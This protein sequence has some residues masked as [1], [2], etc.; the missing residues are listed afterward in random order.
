MGKKTFLFLAFLF[1]PIIIIAQS[2]FEL[3]RTKG[4]VV[5]QNDS[6]F[7]SSNR[8]FKTHFEN[9]KLF[10]LAISGYVEK[11]SADYVVRVILK[12][13]DGHEYLVM[14]LYE[15]L[16]DS[17]LFFFNDYGEETLLLDNVVPDSIKVFLKDADIKISS[18][19]IAETAE[20]NRNYEGCR[21]KQIVSKIE[22]INEY[23]K[24][25][26]R[27]W[28]AGY[29][30]SL[31]QP[32]ELYWKG[33]GFPE[34][35]SSG[36][37]EYYVGGF[38]V[39]GH[40]IPSKR[41]LEEDPFVDSFDW[42]NRHGRNWVSGV[43]NQGNTSYCVAYGALGCLESL[44][45]LYYNN[46]D[47]ELDLSEQEIASCADSIPH[48]FN[49]VLSHSCVLSYIYEHGV[50][51]EVAYPLDTLGYY[52]LLYRP[53]CNSDVVEPNEWIRTMNPSNNVT[54]WMHD[55][56]QQL[57]AKGPLL[58]GWRKSGEMGHAMTLVGYGKIQATDIINLYNTVINGPQ[59]MISIPESYIGS[60]YWIF[61]NSDYANPS[62]T[63]YNL[64]FSSMV[65]DNGNVFIS[66]MS[67]PSSLGLPLESLNYSD[68]DIIVEDA[69]GDGFYNW[70]LGNKPDG[71]PSWI[72]DTPDGDDSDSTKYYMD[73]YGHLHNIVQR[74]SWTLTSDNN[75]YSNNI[76][77][78][79]DIIIPY[80][81]TYTLYGSMIGIG[82]AS[83][84]VESGGKL[85]ID[86]GIWANAKLYLNSGSEV[87][88][89]N[90]GKIYMSSSMIFNAPLGSE[91]TIENGEICGPYIKKSTIWQ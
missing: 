72:P 65:G 11:K 85:I 89:K 20:Q 59:Q 69:D 86:G 75:H 12:D 26:G 78:Y 6:I 4:T 38:F 34:D 16:S 25:N 91:V 58:S 88:I 47:Y 71:C 87:I 48:K 66:N 57:I 52:N 23:N 27:P 18:Y 40:D 14:E 68:D 2:C 5:Y 56:K 54:K 8:V 33:F 29:R 43:R 21:K 83:I 30:D 28:I 44:A 9:K 73:T 49:E 61:K 67:A 79:G 55:I 22:R 80:G 36:G 51:D 50:C 19:T 35:M 13:K 76:Q 7:T 90:G 46:A 39:I 24:R 3:A 45:K 70:G 37:F 31:L 81:R 63:Y 1:M 32:Y 10:A 77:N 15:E 82:S 64:I 42:R 62:E 17:D 53:T 41:S 74:E 84:T 60:T